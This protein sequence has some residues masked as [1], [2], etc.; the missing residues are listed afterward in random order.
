MGN[1]IGINSDALRESN[2]Y[3]Q[4]SNLVINPSKLVT[5]GEI[6]SCYGELGKEAL[7]KLSNISCQNMELK[8]NQKLYSSCQSRAEVFVVKKGW[9]SLAHSVSNR[10][11]DICNVYMPGDIV[12]VRESFFDNHDINLLALENCQL[13]IISVNDLHDLFKDHEDIKRAVVSYVMVN[14]NITIERL[15]SCTHHKAE[16]RVAHFLLEIFARYSFKE[17]LS[18]NIFYFPITQEVVGE[19]LGITSVHVSR[20]MTALEQKKMIRKTRSSIRLLQPDLMAEYTGF[21]EKLIYGH[22]R[23]V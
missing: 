18:S 14:D 9:V 16:D 13:G 5:L 10:G 23:I 19:L 6:L 4:I 20:C 7:E 12:G 21:D 15:R 11:P 3:A 17:R 2:H 8:K 1:A 22:T